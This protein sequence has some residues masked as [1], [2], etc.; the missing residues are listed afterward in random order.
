MLTNVCGILDFAAAGA[1]QIAAQKRFQHQDERVVLA[2]FQ[3]LADD[4]GSR[5]PHL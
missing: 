5:R 2:S 4:V 3:P 1:G